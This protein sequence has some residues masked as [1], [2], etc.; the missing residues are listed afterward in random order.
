MYTYLSP[1][2]S[3]LN[4]YIKDD[5]TRKLDSGTLRSML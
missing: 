5:W 2:H 4:F 3:C 1:F